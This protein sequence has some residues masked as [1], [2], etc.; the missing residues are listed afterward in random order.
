M[1][2]ARYH[3]AFA[4]LYAGFAFGLA[5]LTPKHWEFTAVLSSVVALMHILALERA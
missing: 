3:A 2:R 4:Y 1:T 5:V